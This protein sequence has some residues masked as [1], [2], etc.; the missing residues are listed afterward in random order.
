[1]KEK[2][3][4]KIKVA[5]EAYYI[6]KALEIQYVNDTETKLKTIYKSWICLQE[7]LNNTVCSEYEKEL[8]HY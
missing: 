8:L 3:K 1:M 2:C 4:I 5:I 6:V 7:N